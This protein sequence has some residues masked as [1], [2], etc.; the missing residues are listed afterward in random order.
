MPSRSP[1]HNPQQASTLQWEEGDVETD[2][3]HIGFVALTWWALCCINAAWCT[4]EVTAFNSIFPLLQTTLSLFSSCTNLLE[5]PCHHN[6]LQPLQTSTRL[7]LASLWLNSF[8]IYLKQKA[9]KNWWT[10]FACWKTIKMAP[11]GLNGCNETNS[12]CH[13]PLLTRGI[14]IER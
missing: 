6:S 9:N 4:A 8:N 2:V 12:S 10:G 14:R 13:F 1:C 7:V 3:F 11:W 5:D